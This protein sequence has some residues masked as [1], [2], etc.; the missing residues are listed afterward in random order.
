MNGFW[1]WVCAL[2]LANE[3]AT[4][5]VFNWILGTGLVAIPILVLAA[6]AK[7]G[8]DINWSIG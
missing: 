8:N 7:V 2:L 5:T 6:I 4:D 1:G 3:F